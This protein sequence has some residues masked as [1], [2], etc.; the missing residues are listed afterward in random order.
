M[1]H[2]FGRERRHLRIRKKVIGT[3]KRPRLSVYR[4][5]K[6]LYAQLV[7]DFNRRTLFSMS[8]RSPL[9]KER[10]QYGGNVKAAELFGELFAERAVERGFSRVV[11]DRGGYLYHGRIK[12]FA[13]AVKKKGLKF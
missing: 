10:M 9:F 6:N 8:T 4:S 7:D 11:F 1:T 13:E 3:S 5:L 12:A 2:I